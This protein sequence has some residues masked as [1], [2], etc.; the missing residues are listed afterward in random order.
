[1]LTRA[2]CLLS[3]WLLLGTAIGQVCVDELHA[4]V[5]APDLQPGQAAVLLL[6]RMVRLAEPALPASR[7]DTGP[8]DGAGPAAAAVTYLHQ[9]NLL[10]GN[11][12]VEAHTAATWNT[13][14]RGYARWYG[15]EPPTAAATD[16]PDMVEEAA[17]VLGLVSEA[18]RPLPVFATAE[19][20]SISFF[21]VIWNWTRFPRLLVFPAPDDLRLGSGGSREAAAPV[22]EAMSGCALRFEDFVFAPEDVALRLFVEQGRSTLRLLAT[23]PLPVPFLQVE[24]DEVVDMLRF[25]HPYLEGA[26]AA[27]VAIDGPSPSIT[28]I[29]LIL[30]RLRTN[31]G[32]FDLQ[33]YLS[34]P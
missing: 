29:L 12:R 4:A 28:T 26:E 8:V 14:L 33:G 30:P 11:W 34:F 5:Q 16:L 2:A 23:E 22:L 25:D 18:L 27:G 21:A 13:M 31:L 15:V 1:M 7:R 6:E 17:T 3:I 10:P 32:P 20:G 24:A 19:D 9:R